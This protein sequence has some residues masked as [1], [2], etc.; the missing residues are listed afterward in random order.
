MFNS[1]YFIFRNFDSSCFILSLVDSIS[2]NENL[3]NKNENVK[4][5]PEPFLPSTD[6]IE[7]NIKNFEKNLTER[8]EDTNKQSQLELE[9][10][11]KFND[12][13]L[14]EIRGIRQDFI[15]VKNQSLQNPPGNVSDN[16]LTDIYNNQIVI[17]YLLSVLIFVILFNR[18]W[19]SF[20]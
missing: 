2:D 6:G 9:N 5:F 8:I 10:Q 15:E 7:K 4:T 19:S 1:N 16:S 12:E 13:L 20:K 18:F 11:N 3:V 17:I 14:S